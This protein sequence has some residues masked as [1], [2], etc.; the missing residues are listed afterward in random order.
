MNIF[1]VKV[2]MKNTQLSGYTWLNGKSSWL[3]C[4]VEVEAGTLKEAIELVKEK[5]RDEKKYWI[6]IEESYL[7]L[8]PIKNN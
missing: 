2:T 6:K 4:Y 8:E 7:K 3:D 5:Y 1:M